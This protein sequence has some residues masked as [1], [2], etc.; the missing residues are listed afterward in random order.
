MM[1]D[2]ALIYSYQL[3]VDLRLDL[4]FIEL[5]AEEMLKRNLH[6]AHMT[7]TMYDFAEGTMLA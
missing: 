3:A 1:S 6:V 4:E 2:E 7:S 5:L